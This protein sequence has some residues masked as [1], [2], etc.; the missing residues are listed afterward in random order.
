MSRR[1]PRGRKQQ[2]QRERSR[3]WSALQKDFGSSQSCNTVCLTA[4]GRPSPRLRLLG[5]P[6]FVNEP[7]DDLPPAGCFVIL[8]LREL[9]T[10]VPTSP[11]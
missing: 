7:L 8:K 2:A 9:I 6:H 5:K 10:F 3:R 4:I 11:E 1:R